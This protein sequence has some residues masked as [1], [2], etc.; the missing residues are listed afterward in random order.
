MTHDLAS[1]RRVTCI[2]TAATATRRHDAKSCVMSEVG[3]GSREREIAPYVV[4]LQLDEEI[5][6]PE[7]RA[8]A[9][10]AGSRGCAPFCA[11]QPRQ[12]AVA[13]AGQDD[14]PLVA[15]F[16]RGELEPRVAA[17]GAAEVGLGDP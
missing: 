13:A 12:E 15:R 8:A 4:P 7:H 14:Q 9:L 11:Q 17:I 10:G 6:L 3:E 2:S 16:E 5:L 1:W